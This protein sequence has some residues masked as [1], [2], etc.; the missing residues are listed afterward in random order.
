[1]FYVIIWWWHTL[2][3]G[4]DTNYKCHTPQD[5]NLTTSSSCCSDQT[6]SVHLLHS[7]GQF[8][9]FL[10]KSSHTI[11]IT[12]FWDV[13]LCSWFHPENADSTFVQNTGKRT[14]TG[15]VGFEVLTVMTYEEHG[16]L[17]LT[18]RSMQQ[19]QHFRGT[20]RDLTCFCWL[21]I[22]LIL[23]PWRWK[24]YVPLKYKA[25]S[26]LHSVTTQK[27][28]LYIYQTKWCHIQKRQ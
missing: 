1:M 16:L 9:I 10:H 4:S 7:S 2:T 12:D 8:L 26:K 11:K 5:H 17:F 24:Q 23:W 25:H 21:L 6:S 14:Y 3:D 19:A 20:Y 15:Y 28:I 13:M 27:I 18:E 22:W